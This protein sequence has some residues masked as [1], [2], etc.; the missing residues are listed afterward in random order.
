MRNEFICDKDILRCELKRLRA[1]LADKPEK[2]RL[3]IERLLSLPLSGNV[4]VY[5]SIGSELDTIPFINALR[6][7]SN[8][9]VFTPHTSNGIIRPLPLVRIGHADKLGNLPD[10]CYGTHA[11]PVDMDFCITPMLGFNVD[12]YRIGY[13]KGCY[14]EY[15]TRTSAFKIGLAFDCQLCDFEPR[16]HDVPLD[17]CVTETKVIY[18]DHASNIG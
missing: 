17:C 1:S 12:G 2:S 9:K 13:G 6:E 7:R 3:A 18:F 15:F 5:V 14:D 8:V 10:D 4:L 16:P 11:A